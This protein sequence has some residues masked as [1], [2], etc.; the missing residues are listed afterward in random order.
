MFISSESR[1]ASWG[2][3]LHSF[4]HYHDS[5]RGERTET[6][7]RDCQVQSAS[8]KAKRWSTSFLFSFC[9]SFWGFGFAFASWAA[10]PLKIILS[11]DKHTLSFLSY[12]TH[13]YLCNSLPPTQRASS[14]FY[15][16]S[17]TISEVEEGKVKQEK[18]PI[19]HQCSR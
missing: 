7:L 11:W 16:Q 17:M 13:S 18:S 8:H 3:S 9:D 19:Q 4:N 15:S 2:I 12:F 10:L 6:D 1:A 14:S 5:Q